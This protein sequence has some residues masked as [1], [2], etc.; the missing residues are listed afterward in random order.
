[1]N[2]N[3]LQT[4]TTYFELKVRDCFGDLWT[5]GKTFPTLKEAKAF[6]QSDDA[7]PRKE[8]RRNAEAL[9]GVKYSKSNPCSWQVDQVEIF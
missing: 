9:S 6:L 2:T 8:A 7:E 5:T 1:M 3:T 4:K